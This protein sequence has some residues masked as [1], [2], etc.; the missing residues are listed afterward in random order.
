MSL[1]NQSSGKSALL[2]QAKFEME[3]IKEGEEG[4][5]Q[6]VHSVL[7]AEELNCSSSKLPPFII[8]DARP[9]INAQV[10]TL[11]FMLLVWFSI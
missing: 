3:D 6:S 9:K 8:V 11:H 10:I 4:D 2:N 7:E 1:I 5:D